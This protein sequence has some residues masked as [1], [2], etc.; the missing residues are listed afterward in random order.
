MLKYMKTD[1]DI[2]PL[3][4]K[5]ER[6]DVHSQFSIA[7]ADVRRKILLAVRPYKGAD[8]ILRCEVEKPASAQAC[9]VALTPEF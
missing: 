5:S 6:F 3:G 7:P 4:L 1:D 2:K 9:G 8:R